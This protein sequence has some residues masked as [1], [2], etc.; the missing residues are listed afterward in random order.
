MASPADRIID[1]Y[2]RHAEAWARDRGTKL[3]EKA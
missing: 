2:R 1:L 3:F